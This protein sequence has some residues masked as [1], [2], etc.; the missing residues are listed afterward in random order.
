M[1]GAK[2]EIFPIA[3]APPGGWMLTRVFAA[4]PLAISALFAQQPILVRLDAD[5]IEIF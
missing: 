5:A 2:I 4:R 3:P 1:Y